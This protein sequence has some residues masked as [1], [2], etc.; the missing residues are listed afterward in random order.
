MN[1]LDTF[2]GIEA[3]P[4]ASLLGQAAGLFHFE[5]F[6]QWFLRSSCLLIAN[7]RLAHHLFTH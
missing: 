4:K 1:F 7:Q 6:F 3:V 2:S 5:A